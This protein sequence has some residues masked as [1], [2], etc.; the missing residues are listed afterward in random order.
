MNSLIFNE[1]GRLRSGWR[2]SIFL[3]SFLVLSIFLIL[4][5]VTVLKLLPLGPS[6]ASFLPLVVPFAIAAGIAIF[7]GWI[8]GKIF[9][10]LPFYALGISFRNGWVTNLAIG[11][12]IGAV[13][14]VCSVIIAVM[15]GGMTVEFNRLST[16]SAI[17]ATLLS[18]FVIFFAGAISEEALFRGYFLQTLTRSKQ[19]VLGVGMTS[20]LFALAHDNNPDIGRLSLINT[21]LAGIWFAA[22]YLKTRDLWFPLGVHLMW[23][24]LQGPVFGINVSGIA[25]FS[26]DPLLRSTDHGPMWLTGGDYGIE[27]GLACTIAIVIS[28]GLIYFMPLPKAAP[29]MLQLSSSESIK[30]I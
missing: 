2:A 13:T 7:W 26:P 20:L 15:G 22:A 10:D 27:G 18:T 25:E 30:R 5:A 4:G 1:F 14:F 29:E 19:V 12:V 3:F 6:A 23:N 21:F 9:E 24:W 16:G 17:T 11:C 28:I 8:Y